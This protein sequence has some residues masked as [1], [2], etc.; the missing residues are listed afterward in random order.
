V[1][2]RG[3]QGT[4]FDGKAIT[5][6]CGQLGCYDIVLEQINIV[7]SSPANPAVCSCHNAHGT[8]TS[9]VPNCSCLLPWTLFL[10]SY[11]YNLTIEHYEFN[12]Y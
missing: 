10:P 5:L 7:S 6:D 4:S 1:T 12:K 2:F 9:T 8:A 3:F 11:M